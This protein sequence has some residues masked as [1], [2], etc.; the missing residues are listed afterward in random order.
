MM[1][2]GFEDRLL[3]AAEAA[4]YL[5]YA[6]GTVRN[7]VSRGEIPFVR[8]GRTV[9]FRLSALERWIEDQD[10]AATVGSGATS[11]A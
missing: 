6:E 3:T 2:N 7:K 5:G 10:V 11:D 9:R 8:F 1:N 4:S